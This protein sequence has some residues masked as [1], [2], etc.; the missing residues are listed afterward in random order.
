MIA[1]NT[2][3]LHLITSITISSWINRHNMTIID[4]FSHVIYKTGSN[5]AH[6]TSISPLNGPKT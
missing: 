5:T 6:Q 2:D 4:E 1:L 3:S